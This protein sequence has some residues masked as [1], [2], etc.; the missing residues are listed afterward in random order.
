MN[1]QVLVNCCQCQL[2]CRQKPATQ[3]HKLLPPPELGPA[4]KAFLAPR[5]FRSPCLRRSRHWRE[6]LC[7]VRTGH[8]VSRSFGFR[9][10]RVF[11][12]RLRVQASRELCWALRACL[13]LTTCLSTPFAG[14]ASWR[15][16]PS[17]WRKGRLALRVHEPA[18]WQRPMVLIHTGYYKGTMRVLD[19]HY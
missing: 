17:P 10:F 12:S 3:S 15:T 9:A 1:L 5:R 14:S 6:A 16:H 13:Q 11:G 2:Q 18:E 19:G 7:G 8:R 4:C